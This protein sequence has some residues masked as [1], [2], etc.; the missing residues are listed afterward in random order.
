MTRFDRAAVIFQPRFRFR[1]PTG[2]GRDTEADMK[3]GLALLARFGF[4][5]RKSVAG[6][7]TFDLRL[8]R[9]RAREDR[10]QARAVLFRNRP[11]HP[12]A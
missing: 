11:L 1:L 2:L 12:E 7:D 9:S 10:R 6:P 3:F 5:A 8:E 4:F